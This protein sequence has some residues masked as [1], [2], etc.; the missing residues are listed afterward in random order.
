[1]HLPHWLDGLIQR[2]NPR[3]FGR[4]AQR[5]RSR[6]RTRRGSAP[7][8]VAAWV[9]LLEERTLLAFPAFDTE[10]VVNATIT[11]T[12][13]STAGADRSAAVSPDGTLIIAWTSND[14]S[15]DTIAARRV[16][17]L[18]NLVGG[19]ISV[20]T[21]PS[22]S[23][24]NAVVGTSGNVRFVVVWE[25]VG[26]PLDPSGSGIFARL[27]S[28]NG[29]PEGPEF[30]INQTT[31][32]DQS[33]PSI[34][35]ITADQFV[36]AWSGAGT[37]DSQGIFTR[38]FNA[39]GNP[40]AGEVLV[41]Q[42]TA[43][44]Q[45]EPA[46]LSLPNVGY[47]V[48]WSGN[49]PGDPDGI[50]A[51]PY[52]YSSQPFSNEFR[53]NSTTTGVQQTPA[54]GRNGSG[55]VVQ[56]A[57][58]SNGNSQDTSG[59][60]IFGRQILQVGTPLSNE[61]LI[62]QTTAGDQVDPIIVWFTEQ[63]WV[64]TWSGNG[65][66]D[67]DGVFVREFRDNNLPQTDERLVNSTAAGVQQFPAM[68]P[69]GGGYRNIWSGPGIG[70][71]LGVFT[72]GFRSPDIYPPFVTVQLSN[73]TGRNPSDQIT[74][75]PTIRGTAI[76]DFKVAQLEVALETPATPFANIL[77][78]RQSTGEFVLTRARL[79]QA[80]GRLLA[81]G[82]YTL[83]F[84]AR[85]AV[86]NVSLE[87]RLT[88]TLDTTPPAPP[89]VDLPAFNDTGISPTDNLTR[90][91]SFPLG[92]EVEHSALVRLTRNGQPIGQT[93][94]ESPWQIQQGPL[95]DGSYDFA[96]TAEDVAG[97]RSGNGQPL[98]VI[99][100][101]TPPAAPTIDLPSADDSGR[102]STDDITNHASIT[103]VGSAETDAVVQ[104]NRDGQPAGEAASDGSWQRTQGPLGDAT[105]A[106]TATA[107]D[108]AG[109]VGPSSLPLH[110]TVDTT[111]PAAPVFDLDPVSDTPPVGDHQTTLH[112]VALV[113]QTEPGADV[114]LLP[115][116]LT[117]VADSSSDFAFTAVPLLAGGND[118]TTVA[119]D[120]AGN[121]STFDRTI[122][123][124][125]GF[126]NGLADWTVNQFGGTDPGVGTVTVAPGANGDN[127]A[128]LREGNSFLVTLRRTFV[129]P[130]TPSVLTIEY[131][132]LAFDTTDPSFVNDAFEAALVD[133][134]GNTLVHAFMT[135]ADSF[136]NITE[137]LPA[138]LG[139]ETTVSEATPTSGTITLDVSGIAAGTAAT[140]VLRLVNNDSDTGTQVTIECVQMKSRSAA[141]TTASRISGATQNIV[142]AQAISNSIPVANARF[143]Q[144]ES[145]P[146][147]PLHDS[148]QK[149][150]AESPSGTPTHAKL[151][152]STNYY[153]ATANNKVYRYDVN[154]DGVLT[155][156][157]SIVDSSFDSVF[158]LAIS[159]F[160]QLFASN[161]GN[162]STQNGR[163]TGFVDI[164]GQ[165]KPSAGIPSSS[166]STPFG[167]AFRGNELFVLNQ[168]GGNI[169]RFL[170]D[171]Y[172]NVTPN[173]DIPDVQSPNPG[174]H[175]DRG[176]TVS[177]WGELFVT[178]IGTNSIAR[179]IFD[180]DGVAM[181]NGIISGVGLNNPHDLEFSQWGELFVANPDGYS[182]GTIS[183]FTFD[184]SHNASPNGQI[185][186]GAIN[187][188]VGMAFSPWGDLYVA[189][190][191]SQQPLI[192]RW[193]FDSSLNAHDAGTTAVPDLISDLEFYW[194]APPTIKITSPL[195]GSSFN[196]GTTILASGIADAPVLVD[197]SPVTSYDAA[198]NFFTQLTVA[199]GQH[200]YSVS[201][202]DTY[203]QFAS[204]TLTLTGTP[205]GQID[206]SQFADVTGSLQGLY[207]RTSFNE[208]ANTLFTDTAVRN[209]G[210]YVADAPLLVG[211][212]HLT[213]PRV[214]VRGQTG[215]TPDGLPYYD[216]SHL[217]PIGT[218]APSDSTGEQTLTF[219]NPDRQRFQ[220][221]LTLLGQLN[222]PPAFTSLPV[223]EATVGRT[224]RYDADATDPD[225]DPLHYTLLEAP[226]AMTIDADTGVIN[227]SPQS[228]DQ[229]TASITIR[230][231]DG[232]GAGADQ[233]YVVTVNNPLPN[234]P[235]V[236]ASVPVVSAGVGEA[237]VYYVDAFD[238]DHDSLTFSLVS[239]EFPTGMTIDS[240]TG[241]IQWSPIAGQIGNRSIGLRVEDGRGGIATQQFIVGV[242]G[243]SLESPNI[244]LQFTD[245]DET[246][247]VFDQQLLTVSG[248]ISATLL[249]AGG[250]AITDPFKVAFFEDRNGT[251]IYEPGLDNLF[252]TATVNTVMPVGGALTVSAQF[253]GTALF[254][255]NRI[256]AFADSA[257]IIAET[258]EA[259]NYIVRT[260]LAMPVPGLFNP[261][262][263]WNKSTFAVRPESDQVM[264][265]P[266]V[267][268]LDRDA[269]PDIVF[270]TFNS[271]G[272][273]NAFLRAIS[274][275]DGHELWTVTDPLYKVW[276]IAGIAVGDIDNDGFPEIIAE[277]ESGVPIAFNHDGTVRWLG[278]LISGGMNWGSAALADLDH[279]GVPEII[280]G[281]TVLNANGT[282]QWQGI[283]NGGFGRAD[284]GLGPLSIVADLDLDGTPEIVAARTAYRSNGTVYWNAGITDGFP[285]V[286]NFDADPYP[287][288]VVVSSGWVYLLDHVGNVLWGPNRIPGGGNGGAPTIAD[289][290][291]DGQPEIGVAGAGYYTVFE[292]DGS[293]KWKSQVQDHSSSLTGSSVFD[294]EG[295]GKAEVVY[296]DELY[297]RIYR[298]TDGTVL[299]TFPRG[300]GTTY[301]LP[302]IADV[303]ADGNAEIVV[304]ANS[305]YLGNRTGIFVIGDQTDTW[306]GTRQIWNQHSY[307]VTN[308]NDDG[309]IPR[310]EQNSWQTSNTYRLN[311]FPD[312]A[313]AHLAP[314]LTASFYRTALQDDKVAV[315]VRIGNGGSQFVN[316]GV[317]IALYDGDP[318][319]GG[320]LLGVAATTRR[321][322]P[323]EY[324]DVAISLVAA[325]IHDLWI[326][327]DDDGTG[328]GRVGECD[329]VNN[330]FATGFSVA[331][332]NAAPVF[333]S[334]PLIAASEG[335]AYQY[336]VDAVDP[337]GDLLTFALRV[338]PLGMTIDSATGLIAWNPTSEDSGRR[339]VQ[340]VVDDGK[341]GRAVQSFTI[342]VA[343]SLN[344]SPH[345]ISTSAPAAI[346][347]QEYR[348]DA[349]A[350]DPEGD[351]L[352]Y[353]LV[354]APA[355]MTV[356]LFSGV[357][358]WT[359]PAEGTFD[360]VLRVSDGKGGV[361]L[362]SLELV[363]SRANTA[364][365]ITSQP[366][367]P[368]V[369]AVPWQYQALA[370]DADG[371]PLTFRLDAK[372]DNMTIDAGTGLVRWTPAAGQVGSAHVA[373][374]ADDGHGAATTQFFDLPVVATAPNEPPT[375]TSRPRGSVRLGDTY[376]YQVVASDPNSDP[377]TYSLATKPDGMSIDAT[378]LVSWR[379]VAAQF[380]ANDV[381]V[382]VADGRGLSVTQSFKIQVVSQT[383]NQPPGISSNPPGTATVGRSYAYDV[384]ASDPDGDPL[385]FSL[386]AA[387]SGMSIDAVRGTIRWTPGA[388]QTG[389]QQVMLRASDSAGGYATQTY[390]IAVRAVNVPPNIVSAPLTT[391]VVGQPY[392]YAVH[393]TDAEGDQLTF[394]LAVK[395]AG[396]TIDADSGLVSWTPTAQQLGNQSV[397]VSVADG[398]GGT[399]SQSWQVVVAATSN[400]PPVI[401]STP[402]QAATQG[403][404][405][406]YQVTASDPDGDRLT[407]RLDAHPAGMTI[408]PQSGAVSW[409]PSANQVG[410]QRVTVAA[411][412]PSGAGGTQ[413]FEI[414]VADNN[415]PPTISSTAPNTLTAGLLYRYDVQ[416]SDP[417]G[418]PLTLALNQGPAGMTLDAL[419]RLRWQTDKDDAGTH[420][421]KL[422]VAD[423]RGGFIEQEFE[424]F[425][426]ADVQ[427]PRV[428]LV[429]SQN[430]VYVG[431]LVTLV[432]TATD[433]VG[434]ASIGLTINGNPVPLDA[435]G[436][437]T[438][439]AEP[440]GDYT[441]V[442]SASD[443]AGR[444]G[445]A[446]TTL[447][448]LVYDETFPV[449]EITAP[450]GS[451]TI[452]DRVDVMGTVADDNLNYYSLLAAPVGT[453]EF[454]EL[455]RG[456][457][458]VNG[459]KL[460]V[461]D[462]TGLANGPYVLRLFAKDLGGNE[463]ST[464][465]IVDVAGDLK[466]G[467]F[468]LS[469]TDLS[470]PVSGIPITVSRTYDSLNA[471]QNGEL[472]Y[473]W[474]LEF[475]DMHLR[476]SVP[477]TGDEEYGVYN[478][479]R[480]GSRVY[481]T[482]PGGKREG[483][484]FK[485][486]PVPGFA[487]SFL[488]LSNPSFDSDPGVTNR[489]SVPDATLKRN[490]FGE[491]YAFVSGGALNY[492][493]TDSL[494][495]GGVFY[496]TTKE[497]LK[498][499]IDAVTGD[500]LHLEDPSSNRLTF[501]DEAIASNRGPRI[502]F[503]RDPQGRVIAAV[504]PLQNKIRYQYDAKGDLV[505]V[506]DR[507]GNRTQFV[508]AEP[509]RPHFLT[510]VIDPLGRQGVRTDYDDQGRLITLIDAA[511]RQVTLTHRPDE[512]IEVVT[513][514]LGHSTTFVYDVR[515]NVVTEINHLGQKTTR[516]YDGANNTLTE[517]NDLGE[518][519]TYTYNSLGDVLTETDPLGR[520][521]TYTYVTHR[522]GLFDQV[523]GAQVVSLQATVTD[524]LGNTTTNE[525]A[526]TNLVK[527]TDAA[528]HVTRFEYDGAGNQTAIIDAAGNRTTFVYDGAGRLVRQTDAQGNDT[529][530][531]YDD[532]GNQLTQTTFVTIDG[533]KTPVVTT[534]QYDLSGRA[535]AVTDPLGHT[536]RTEY[537]ALGQQSAVI[538][539]LGRKTQFVYDDRGQLVQTIFPDATPGDLTDNPRTSTEYDAA[540]HAI[541]R[542]DEAGVVTKFTYDEVGRLFETILPDDTPGDDSDNPRTR[543]EYDAAGRVAAQID[544]LGH[545]T[546][547]T[548]DAA[549]R[550]TLV[551]DPLGNE[552]HT[553]YDAA[554]R[555]VSTTDA[556]GHTTAFL[557][558]ALG[559][560]V[561]T[562]FADA[563]TRSSGY[564][565]LGRVATETDQLGRVTRYEY[566]ALGRLTAVVDALNQRT[567]YGYDE[568]GNLVTQTDANGHVTRYEY[569]LLGRKVQTNLPMGQIST[570]EYDDAGNV[571][572]S[573]DFNG[574]AIT[575][576]YD[577]RNRLVAKRY[578]DGSTVTFEYGATGRREAEH[579]ARGTTTFEYDLRDRLILRTDPDGTTIAWTYDAAGN[580]TSVTTHVPGN[581]PQTTNYT[582]DALNRLATVTDPANGVTTYDYDARGSLTRTFY[583]SGVTETRT[584]DALGRLLALV[585]KNSAGAVLTSY[586]YTL[587][588]TGRRDS[589]LEAG[590]RRV[591][592]TYDGLD[593]LTGE[594]ILDATAG[595]RTITYTYDPVGNRLTRSDSAEGTTSS[596]YDENDRLL[597]ETL[598]SVVTTYTYSDAG[599]TL[600]KT[601]SGGASPGQ[602]IYHWDYDH[603]LAAVDTDGTID[604]ENHYNPDGL[605]VAQITHLAGPPGSEEE[606]RY[607]L[608]TVQPYAQVL[609][610]YTH[611]GLIL[612]SYTHGHDL[613]SQSRQAQPNPTPGTLPTAKSFYLVD[614]LGST[615]ALTDPLGLVTDRYTYEAFGRTIAQQGTTS[616]LYLFAGEQRDF[617]VGLDYLRARYL[618]VE[619]GSFF[620]RDPFAGIRNKP[621]SQHPY[622]YA[623]LDPG[624]RIDPSG[625]FTL[626]ELLIAVSIIG[627]T[628]GV[629]S[630]ALAQNIIPVTAGQGVFLPSFD[631]GVKVEISRGFYDHGKGKRH[632]G[633]D[634]AVDDKTNVYTVARGRVVFQG[635]HHQFGSHI[636][637]YHG[638]SKSGK[639]YYTFYAHHEK[640]LVAMNQIVK[641]GDRIALSGH[642]GQSRGAHLHFQLHVVAPGLPVYQYGW[643]TTSFLEAA[644]DPKTTNWPPLFG[645]LS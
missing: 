46:V 465:T 100:D 154:P 526:G 164:D 530:Y 179:F 521:T 97:N 580:R 247:V 369:V 44:T 497:G 115:P 47:E 313:E 174:G 178:Q 24:G 93:I 528:G 165:L 535:I 185:E 345:F 630:P 599:D 536:T 483:F 69:F 27:F 595:N 171:R 256:F 180:A 449:V 95:S 622:V 303:D 278:P 287:E 473:G 238:P 435:N 600:S 231:T 432:V 275:S 120:V 288:I 504:D 11:G 398:Q 516:T 2:L 117:T 467:N 570:T 626:I 63:E 397:T 520:V 56:L 396:M 148:I 330:R 501:T 317:K 615:R 243:Q 152:V 406:T 14:G 493:P 529:L 326:V 539:A 487:G 268:D 475:R 168:G 208:K 411:V 413:S 543:T 589:V 610:E 354:V 384:V 19:E 351:L 252:G 559:R 359:P 283:M 190:H 20:S 451:K 575:F 405:Y 255:D 417:D 15:G 144:A 246:G 402:S 555:V 49:G 356:Q 81:D 314:D 415:R 617:G 103:L 262:V 371:D 82:T 564:D 188:P 109:N 240:Q 84:R 242:R 634:Y 427:S 360:A 197:G 578:P 224:Y 353:D 548:Y 505:G 68:R 23:A 113:G 307:H 279:D 182:F 508:Y 140:L 269:I 42:T 611:S 336:D 468:T 485:P 173:G 641:K 431:D 59:W 7:S 363:V 282:I 285:A 114:T 136:F 500:L 388:D 621:L 572:R 438:L 624:N 620:G 574:D 128:T 333:T 34:A 36:V 169:L 421:V 540:G 632:L 458:T 138:A 229:G 258:N 308:I 480:N 348:Y 257:G 153:N 122:V 146:V 444:T 135:G 306:V 90:L 83:K 506:T 636:V 194:P 642:S 315:T 215:T 259:N 62:N 77:D 74:S 337:D 507:E 510:E 163:L 192:G 443:A 187:S 601:T 590:G 112:M 322:S 587:V 48:A 531:T 239:G 206:F 635:N 134:Q 341:R 382:T 346:I 235:P 478:A 261:A 291:G 22:T 211:V 586:D 273:S 30:R 533:V 276:P 368:A 605:R 251:G 139:A 214:F 312:P 584:Y 127:Q 448:V 419:G 383:S 441:I 94:A 496:L 250:D 57:W 494:N 200:T 232:R 603:R 430:P 233:H 228:A 332:P 334:S 378:G 390:S 260:C 594:S 522:P 80:L 147:Q 370:Q 302:V 479:Y 598:G 597:T 352:T 563:T 309:S 186:T 515:G 132:N 96:A 379:P 380:G 145:G 602:I 477:P 375:I 191:V 517:T 157:T 576:E 545:R 1:M 569:D 297:L 209:V 298:G 639:R 503:E 158:G 546:E 107:E 280:I 350:I 170:V 18:S 582:F 110:V 319:V 386:D 265:T 372:P 166:F 89:T 556:L 608:D 222:Q 474:R 450:D 523:R 221:D 55:H 362:Q 254:F 270:S 481:V 58:Q 296:A 395:P 199:A 637:V 189:N 445:L 295:D 335:L 106:F 374:T 492:N 414:A 284:N 73:D 573:V 172:G 499:T 426:A 162:G 629:A 609:L 25:S 550:Q 51:R 343:E 552:T 321:L 588:A 38:V 150:T 35:W 440:A 387:P 104:L 349:D 498:Y 4:S 45:A 149:A 534:T 31:S 286:G 70:D 433:N 376:L 519:T 98:T 290:D 347:G 339:P 513:D 403:K 412:D 567:Q 244:D 442:G 227:W 549:G 177:P 78:I 272:G 509:G 591:N 43:G 324:E 613:I 202:T 628:V 581:A 455:F 423:N 311:A 123:I 366:K 263:E 181:P 325:G 631:P 460:G 61:I 606:T 424:L 429:V 71:D 3:A 274:G 130:S 253:S 217:V 223:L 216:Y 583:P 28:G 392:V 226:S 88:F 553:T 466:L 484:T 175:F 17:R 155:F 612:V 338:A 566:D 416:F 525:Y 91:S 212:D 616:N 201:T 245:L 462:P 198:G 64:V 428:N 614:G 385:A 176:I 436:R 328:H 320:Q 544:E 623:V 565:A 87:T 21:T 196:A 554:G 293:E 267:I 488:G 124:D 422:T 41:N 644:V 542:T 340:V 316:A 142:S 571:S 40:V 12:Q 558:D 99:V 560:Q 541:A 32:G 446:S 85:D 213:D 592:Y 418:D 373:I 625:E 143:V 491:F 105:Y 121:A 210:Q 60:G 111:P 237:Y 633:I 137:D 469:F 271:F 26:N 318:Q 463:S 577:L 10:M 381:A 219:F 495:F 76:D 53:V 456:T 358:T 457:Q 151:F 393:A 193:T 482:L 464:D 365:V 37:G 391:A 377:L 304:I 108:L 454:I 547:F 305:Y 203:G 160:G 394:S 524:P 184:S 389:A 502:T 486:T 301:E 459:S 13:Q 207:A 452:R 292:T 407:F 141:E 133:A 50:F 220:F 156:E 420:R 218:L 453:N 16:D 561:G 527:T 310:F 579:D 9:D 205:P 39:Q 102:S 79:E 101:T 518:T 357:V 236:I 54:M 604:I 538:D 161:R 234:R 327:S 264:M 289:F 461:F 596:T 195:D 225:R 400:R 204:T 511:G 329:E 512:A 355:G 437:I 342:E 6:L 410:T 248:T 241:V 5:R 364:P 471:P 434:V 367:G 537:N 532:N 159:P 408:D 627:I 72:R 52:T 249:N 514:Q 399:A 607:L 490:E 92:G 551:R 294:F 585:N 33:D 65:V 470:V 409:T 619:G 281:S 126:E 266:A 300:S 230:V 323:G 116:G 562:K 131:V 401:T 118:F 593:R 489:L 75:D 129:I 476:T 8:L 183:R 66:G 299:Y 277:H 447:H 67:T 439:R 167:I 331:S 425:V 618:N 645:P 640:N 344:T 86:G 568:A 472:G 125:C 404:P 557:L 119:T 361:D 638:T 643:F 29:T